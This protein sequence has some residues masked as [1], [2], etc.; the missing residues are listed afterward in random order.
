MGMPSII[1]HLM[2]EGNEYKNPFGTEI[3]LFRTSEGGMARFAVSWDTPG[4][5]GE[6]GRIHGQKGSFD[7]EYRGTSPNLP[8]LN[9]PSLPPGVTPGGHG[10][11]H[12][13]LMDD[14]V[15]SIIEDREPTVDIATAL[16]MTV[17]GLVAHQSALKD[18]EIMKIP[19]YTL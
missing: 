17:P 11:S 2:P 5:H 16:N 15:M 8:N 3:G 1:P 13:Y 12:G 18:S 19:Q 14:F 4:G 7:N 6:T 9:K 10:G